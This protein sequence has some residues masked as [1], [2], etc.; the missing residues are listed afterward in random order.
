MPAA[1]TNDNPLTLTNDR[2]RAISARFVVFNPCLIVASRYG[3]PDP[4]NGTNFYTWATGLTCTVSGSPVADGP[5]T[6]FVCVGWSGTGSVPISGAATGVTITLTNDSRIAWNW[7]TQFWLAVSNDGP[8]AIS[9]SNS[10]QDARSNIFIRAAADPG[11]Q[12]AGWSGDVPPADTN[13]NPLTLAM[14]RSRS[15]AGR[16]VT[17]YPLIVATC[18]LGGAIAP[19]GNYITTYNASVSFVIAPSNRFHLTNV[20]VDGVSIGVVSNYD[21]LNITSNHTIAAYFA[22]D[23]YELVVT[24]PFGT[25]YPP[26]GTNLLPWHA[27]NLACYVSGSPVTNGATRY[28]CAG[29][30]GGGSVPATGT[31]T[32]TGPFALATNSFITWIWTTQFWL[33]VTSGPNGAVV[34]TNGWYDAGTNAIVQ[35]VPDPGYRFDGWSG[36]APAG[37]TNR[38]RLNLLMNQPRALAARFST[39]VCTIQADAGGFTGGVFVAGIFGAIAPTGTVILGPGGSQLYTN[40]PFEHCHLAYLLVDD[41]YV[42]PT[43][44]YLFSNVIEDHTIRAVYDIDK[45]NLLIGSTYSLGR[46]TPPIGL[47]TFNWN[48][49]VTCLIT[50]SPHTNGGIRWFCTGW[51]NGTG[52]IP[53]TGTNA[54]FGPFTLT[55]HSSL[56]WTWRSQYYFD[57]RISG[58]GAV[59][60]ASGWYDPGATFLATATAAPYFQFSSWSGD[61]GGCVPIGNILA[62]DMNQPRQ[63]TAAFRARLA[64]RGTPQ[65]WLAKYGWTNNFDAAETND[66]DH[67]TFAADQEYIADTDP[68]DGNDFFRFTHIT[69]RASPPAIVLAWRGALDRLYTVDYATNLFAPWQPTS[70]NN[71]PGAGGPMTYTNNPADGIRRAF[72]VRVGLQ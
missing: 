67:D 8:G 23:T 17:Y 65:W 32:N 36:D 48:S 45:L 40:T 68:T 55:N 34:A 43:N 58:T 26:A 28:V 62:V 59:D 6:Q 9:P 71:R 63:V 20:V 53:P 5:L 21:F 10:W 52:D 64:A 4:P 12:F 54:S 15:I 42:E 16:F 70:F 14:T 30:T 18:S 35:A 46:G 11:Y 38:A 44:L 41:T 51:T 47:S 57:L 27:T 29:W 50:N 13:N 49:T 33:S 22:V 31:G 19:Y 39:N 3:T 69:S 72:Q 56:T 60:V 1:N 24:T 2:P 25:A 61:L 37:Q 66:T 7:K